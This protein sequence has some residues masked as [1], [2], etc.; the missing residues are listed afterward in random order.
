MRFELLDF[1]NSSMTVKF[2]LLESGLLC[3]DMQPLLLLSLL[4]FYF[5]SRLL[6]SLLRLISEVFRHYVMLCYVLFCFVTSLV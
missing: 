4:Q 6:H 2:I 1:L 3:V 5:Q